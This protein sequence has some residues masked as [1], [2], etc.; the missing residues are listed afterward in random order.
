MRRAAEENAEERDRV[1]TLDAPFDGEP[2]PLMTLAQ[3][4]GGVTWGNDDLAFVVSWWWKTR[5]LKVWRV[6]PDD[7]DFTP[8][9]VQDRSFQDRY[10]DPD[11]PPPLVIDDTDP[12]AAE[13]VNGLVKTVA[14]LLLS[15][16]R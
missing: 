11:D 5:N 13:V 4:Y 16:G 8:V 1:Y 7:R 10:A 15:P 3:R 2:Q 14:S 6:K 12:E 9:A